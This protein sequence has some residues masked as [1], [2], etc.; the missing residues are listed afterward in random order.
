MKDTMRYHLIPVAPTV[1]KKAK[2]VNEYTEKENYGTQFMGI[3]TNTITLE[4]MEVLQNMKIESL[5]NSITRLLDINL[6]KLL[7]N[8]YFYDY[9]NTIKSRQ[10]STLACAI[11]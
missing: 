11:E 4:Y 5:Y 9:V 6:K 10:Q 3:L 8:L 7:E 1:I 2:G